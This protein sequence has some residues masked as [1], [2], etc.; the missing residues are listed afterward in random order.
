MNKIKIGLC[1][2]GIMVF[3]SCSILKKKPT[4]TKNPV[5]ISSTVLSKYEKIIGEKLTFE[6]LYTFIDQWIN[7]PY[8]YGGKSKSG[9]DCSNFTCQLLREVYEFPSTYYYPSSK[10]VEQ[11]L[12]ISQKDAKEGDLVFFS[13][14]SGSKISH[15]GVYLLNSKFVHASTT[16]GV[17]ISSLNED[18]Y[19]KRFVGVYRMKR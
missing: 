19:Q 5:V 14:N 6:E 15:V 12:K 4:K 7:V 16:K 13:M 17:M 8:K 1:L 2:V 10:L 9:I 3:S 11:G 18:Y